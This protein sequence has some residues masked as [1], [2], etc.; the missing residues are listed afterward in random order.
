MS[1]QVVY[2][3][4]A[5]YSPGIF[6]LTQL[7]DVE[8]AHNFQDL[9]EWA[10][11]QAGPQ[12]TGTHQA[13][14]DNRFSTAQLKTI[15]DVLI[16]GDENICRDLSSGDV[17]TEYKAGDNRGIRLPDDNGGAGGNH[18]FGRMQENAFLALES[19][20]ARAGA[21][22]E[23]RCRLAAVF[24]ASTGNDPLVWTD[25][26]DITTV[27]DI[28]HLFTLGPVKLNGTFL[29]GVEDVRVE[30]NPEYDEVT[31]SGEPFLSY[32]GIRRY[33]P[34]VT[35][36]S[37]NAALLDTFGTRGTALSAL[38]VFWRKKLQS[39]IVVADA[40]AE[41]ISLTG[42]AGTIKARRV[43]SGNASVE[44]TIDLRKA[45]QATNPFTF[46]TA[47]AIS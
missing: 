30:I 7:M 3:P 10:A 42:A 19:I 12:F 33:R 47:T 31:D 41:H 23:L 15:I 14:P 39:G 45:N 43:Q 34:V 36:M 40:T 6:T 38:S 16:A 37:R 8:P 2:Y 46:N 35:V 5:I 22:A 26:N 29:G 18:L 11:S 27:S 9:T 4:H 17:Y 24:N 21:V 25:D 1:T 13:A 20:S 32:I 44:L 28:A